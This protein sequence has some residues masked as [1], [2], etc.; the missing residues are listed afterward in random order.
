MT[1]TDTA[2][3]RIFQDLFNYPETEL[4][5]SVSPEDV[6]GWDSMRHL[7]LAQEIES[8]FGIRLRTP[9]ILRMTSVGEIRRILA[10]NSGKEGSD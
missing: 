8:A 10:N 1:D 2:L 6:Q 5:D 7:A 3:L 4:P 9:D